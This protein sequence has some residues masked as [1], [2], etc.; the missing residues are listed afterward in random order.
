MLVQ[1]ARDL[2][3]DFYSKFWARSVTLLS[4]S[5]NHAQ[6]SVIEVCPLQ[7]GVLIIGCLQYPLVAFEI[8]RTST[9]YESLLNL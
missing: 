9:R 3:E 8:P 2:G 7:F 5:V 1:L 4:Q 6:F